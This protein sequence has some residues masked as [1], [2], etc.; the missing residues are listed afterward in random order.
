MT[1]ILLCT[2]GDYEG[3]LELTD[4]GDIQIGSRL[5]QDIK[6][7]I[8][9]IEGEWRLGPDLGLPWYEDILVKNPN[10]DL[11]RQDIIN[12]ITDIDGVTGADVD[13]LEFDRASRKIKI[14][15]TATTDDE[16]Y[17]GEAIIGG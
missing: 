8:S 4:S 6:T 2:G 14:T 5:Y 15:F 3:D 10:L 11:V 13:I 7:A 9:W 12:A 1:D 17:S 16:A